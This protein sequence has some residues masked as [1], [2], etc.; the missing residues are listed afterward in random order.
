[1]WSFRK[2]YADL[3]ADD[4]TVC[5]VYAVWLDVLGARSATC[6]YEL[7]WPDGRREV[8]RGTSTVT[9]LDV[10]T[11][12]GR[13]DLQFDVPGGRFSF[14]QRF[15]A[16][17]WLPSGDGPCEGL[18]WS[19]RTARADAEAR[20]SIDGMPVLHGR[21]YA[22]WVELRKPTRMLALERVS[23]GRV[24]M[25]RHSF[26]LNR[27]QLRSGQEWKRCL[28]LGPEGRREVH[29]FDLTEADD[30]FHVRAGGHQ[31]VLHPQRVLH[32][33]PAL[34]RQRV[35]GGMERLLNWVATGRVDETRWVSRASVADERP[36]G[37]A[38]HETVNLG[39]GTA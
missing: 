15:K 31:L 4:G 29:D 8:V 21:G 16:D 38:L 2:L 32:E 22:D 10:D 11:S 28:V 1:M 35:P 26:V 39:G 17:A 19:V 25:P 20:W 27:I 12:H 13:L 36:S 9:E 3:V 24:H 30:G 7:Y 23:W 34:D 33:G 14:A 18:A 5:I 6:G 37:W